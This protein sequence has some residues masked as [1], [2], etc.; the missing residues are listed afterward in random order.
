MRSERRVTMEPK[1][2]RAEELLAELEEEFFDRQAKGR[3]ISR[4]EI[5]K[6]GTGSAV[7]SAV[8]IGGLME[9]LA[10]REAVAAGFIV[11]LIGVTREPDEADETPH[12]HG[13]VAHFITRSVSP[14]G[15]TGSVSGRTVNVISTGSQRE[16][17]HFHLIQMSSVS[18][19]AVIASGPENGMK[20]G[21]SHGVSIE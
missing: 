7:V 4:R 19:E 10:N 1:H 20:G 18:L 5:L 2:S 8:G 15:I 3:R 17:P 13:F 9:L 14:Q 21:H 16:D 6:F 12:R 11:G